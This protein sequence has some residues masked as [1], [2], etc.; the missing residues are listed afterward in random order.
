MFCRWKNWKLI[1]GVS[2][3]LLPLNNETVEWV[4]PLESPELPDISGDACIKIDSQG[5]LV[6]R[7]LFDMKGESQY[8]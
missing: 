5:N 7:C 3:S 2:T 8:S 6:A 1:Y 4:K